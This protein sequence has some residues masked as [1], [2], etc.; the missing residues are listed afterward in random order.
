MTK[1]AAQSV[2]RIAL[3]GD[4]QAVGMD[5]VAM[6]IETIRGATQQ[7]VDGLRQIEQAVSRLQHLEQD[8]S[9]LTGHTSEHM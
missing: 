4:Q 7:H 5:Q 8:L 9:H 3:A 2:A 1:E 6:A